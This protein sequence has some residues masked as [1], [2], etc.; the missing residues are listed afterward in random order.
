MIKAHT[1][2][3]IELP[4]ADLGAMKSFYGAAFGWTFTDYGPTY[5]SFS[6][7]GLDG[8]FDADAGARSP[9]NQGALVVLISEDL[10][11]SERAIIAAG[12][13]ISVPLF[14]FPGGQRFHFTD[15]S[16]NELAVWR[17]TGH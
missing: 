3:Y 14:D 10:A 7:A 6:G 5:A 1:I 4:A 12:G 9:S 11:A 2:N 13:I 16:G 17:M 15:P 8:G